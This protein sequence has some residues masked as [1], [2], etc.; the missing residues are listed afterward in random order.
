MEGLVSEQAKRGRITL[1]IE[2]IRQA[3]GFEKLSDI[4]ANRILEGIQKL[5]AIIVEF[6]KA[7]SKAYD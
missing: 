1:T 6:W 7:K 2:K 5:A 3:K 4:E